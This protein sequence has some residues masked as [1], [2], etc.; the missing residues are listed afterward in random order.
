MAVD[1][2]GGEDR[3]ADRVSQLIAEGEPQVSALA[4]IRG[5]ERRAGRIGPDQDR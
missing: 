4:V 2:R 3:G 5:P 1:D